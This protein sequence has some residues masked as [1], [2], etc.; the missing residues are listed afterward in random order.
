M[1]LSVPLW[2]TSTARDTLPPGYTSVE[3][4]E[5]CAVVVVS[6][7]VGEMGVVV[8]HPL[9]AASVAMSNGGSSRVVSVIVCSDH[10]VGL[11]IDGIEGGTRSSQSCLSLVTHPILAVL[12]LP[13]RMNGVSHRLRSVRTPWLTAVACGVALTAVACNGNT[14]TAPTETTTTTTTTPAAEPSIVEAFND[15]LLVGG[16]KLYSFTVTQYG[17]VTV[18][19]TSMGGAFVPAT[20]QIALGLG[21]PAGTDCTVTTPLT[22]SASETAHITGLLDPGIYCVRVTDIGNLYAPASFAISIA[23]P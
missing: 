15:T 20:V 13:S 14:V 7:E 6:V 10:I 18:T 19:L 22:V 12:R 11:P 17:T 21:T 23:H 5:G 2:L 4:D 1:T 9:A 3:N 16:S 8:P